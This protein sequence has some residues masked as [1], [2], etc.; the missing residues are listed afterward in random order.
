M[1]VDRDG[2]EGGSGVREFVT[3][4]SNVLVLA[5]VMDS[6]V[7]AVCTNLLRVEPV[8]D[9]AVLLVT[10]T[11]SADVRV[12]DF[13]E[14]VDSPP[15]DL[16]VVD[17]SGETRSGA[18]GPSHVPGR[19]VDVVS[20]PT[21]LTGL[22]IAMN[23]QLAEWA[24]DDARI[25]VCVHTL[26][27]LLQYASEERVFQFLHV[28]TNRIRSVDAVAHYHLDPAAVG[29]RTVHTLLQ[30]FDVIVRRDD[31]GWKIGARG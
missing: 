2:S 17:V 21:D 25:V 9:E 14:R 12:D 24:R 19:V 27:T 16:H 31:E 23:E 28:L 10:F 13:R 11:Q 4:G 22:G 3:P 29:D 18:D 5:P 26:T 6:G 30:L 15:G 1:A 20:S 7:G 8:A